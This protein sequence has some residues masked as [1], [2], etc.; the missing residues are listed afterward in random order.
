MSKETQYIPPAYAG[1]LPHVPLNWD[2]RDEITGKLLEIIEAV[3][4]EGGQQEATKR[5]IKKTTSQFFEDKY[6]MV[7]YCLKDELSLVPE[8]ESYNG[9]CHAIWMEALR[10]NRNNI[11]PIK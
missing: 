11:S 1:Q 4:P 6:N 5:L 9:Y 8:H 2:D 7:F 3:L 10:V